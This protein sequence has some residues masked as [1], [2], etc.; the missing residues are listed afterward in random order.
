VGLGTFSSESIEKVQRRR[1]KVS[2]PRRSPTVV[3]YPVS[4]SKQRTWLKPFKA[5]AGGDTRPHMPTSA[6]HAPG[7][8]GPD[9]PLCHTAATLSSALSKSRTVAIICR[10]GR[11][12]Q[13]AHG[14]SARY[15]ARF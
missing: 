12:H 7:A 4:F 10:S 6:A 5:A 2:C 1:H 8:L 9:Q 3:L 13:A 15:S 14:R 11:G